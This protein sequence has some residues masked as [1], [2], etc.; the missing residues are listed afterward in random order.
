[1]FEDFV[2]A[3]EFI[4]R[5]PDSSGKVGSVGFCY[6]GGV[7]LQLA[8]RIPTLAA[9]VS[10]YGV[11][12][13]PADA[14]RIHAPLMLHHGE[15]DERV[16]ASWPEFEKALQAEHKDYVRYLYA[17]ANHGF[18]N[19]TTPRFDDQAASL[20]WQRTTKFFAEHLGLDV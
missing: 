1:M 7:S 6:G 15:L 14:K 5:H 11:H 20:S 19:D 3:V 18:H 8:V 17:G 13:A 4:A 16:N 2:A 9:A 12:P 10:Y